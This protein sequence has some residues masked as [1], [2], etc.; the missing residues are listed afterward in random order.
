MTIGLFSFFQ[1]VIVTHLPPS[2]ER[3]SCGPHT[4]ARLS[5]WPWHGCQTYVPLSPPTGRAVERGTDMKTFI[6][7]QPVTAKH[8]GHTS[9]ISR[10]TQIQ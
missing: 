10:H 9:Y 5:G 1:K 2:S 6:P 3:T 4:C 7:E 8:T